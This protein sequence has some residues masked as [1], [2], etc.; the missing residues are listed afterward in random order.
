MPYSPTLISRTKDQSR[1]FTRRKAS[2]VG[3]RPGAVPTPDSNTPLGLHPFHHFRKV[4]DLLNVPNPVSYS[5]CR[6]GKVFKHV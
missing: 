1:F 5:L 4:I 6:L 3:G 2:S